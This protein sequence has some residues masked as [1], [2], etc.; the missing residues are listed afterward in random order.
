[1]DGQEDEEQEI[2]SVPQEIES[3]PQELE[4]EYWPAVE[5]V[6]GI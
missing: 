6:Y 1:M 2:G 3:V 5:D 4:E